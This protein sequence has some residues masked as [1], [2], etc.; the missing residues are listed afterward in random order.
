[1]DDSKKTGTLHAASKDMRFYGLQTS[2]ENMGKFSLGV[3]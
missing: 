1:V 3:K 2:I